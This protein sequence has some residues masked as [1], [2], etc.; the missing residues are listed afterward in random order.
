[1]KDLCVVKFKN[2]RYAIR[3]TDCDLDFRYLDLDVIT[4]WRYDSSW[5]Y[6]TLDAFEYCCTTD[7]EEEILKKFD[8]IV[9][10]L[11]EESSVEVIRRFFC[12]AE[13]D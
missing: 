10:K 2:G 5:A 6:N 11:E 1:M 3:K 7:S 12:D 13:L 8:K 9:N 4:R